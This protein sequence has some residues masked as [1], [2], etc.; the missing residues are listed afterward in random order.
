LK[1]RRQILIAFFLLLIFWGIWASAPFRYFAGISRDAAEKL[2]AF[3]GVSDSLKALGILF[4]LYLCI[5][6]LIWMRQ[7]KREKYIVA[8][9]VLISSVFY[10]IA[11]GPV[12]SVPVQHFAGIILALTVYAF[13]LKRIYRWAMDFYLLSIPVL[14][15]YEAFFAPLF[16]WLRLNPDRLH[17]WIS[18]PSQTALGEMTF[19]GWPAL[20]WGM[21]M[22]M[23]TLIA[24][25]WYFPA[26][27]R[28]KKVRQRTS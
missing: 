3:T 28:I 1:E 11:S 16:R 2:I 22:M 6:G 23:V 14:I 10:Y 12:E 26:A 24:V 15:I 17:P 13:D 19:F 5:A 27:A 25:A 4:F 18:I 20:V 21:F 8:I 9:C 7:S